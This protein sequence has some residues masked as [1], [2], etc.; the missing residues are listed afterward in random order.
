MNIEY[1]PNRN[2]SIASVYDFKSYKYYY[3]LLP[4]NAKVGDIIKSGYTPLE[5]KLGHSS[6]IKYIP[7]GSII[8]NIS[9]RF[10]QKAIFSRS[11]GTYSILIAKIKNKALIK[12]S[13]GEGLYL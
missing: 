4:K 7:A 5:L 2:T 6:E 10:K 12:L 9:I 11:A 1:D 8:H 3:I 13:S